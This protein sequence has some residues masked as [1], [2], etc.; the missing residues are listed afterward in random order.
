MVPQL[1][2]ESGG[3]CS[4]EE[5][6][7]TRRWRRMYYRLQCNLSSRE[8]CISPKI[9]LPDALMW[10]FFM[11]GRTL[12][13]QDL[14]FG[15]MVAVGGKPC[16]TSGRK[17][18]TPSPVDSHEYHYGRGFYMTLDRRVSLGLPAREGTSTRRCGPLTTLL[19]L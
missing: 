19:I 17:R 11:G 10:S 7:G 9:N 12:N 15:G 13:N 2:F 3:Q 18:E 1:A 14:G 8:W 5:A 16:Q 4:F 6:L